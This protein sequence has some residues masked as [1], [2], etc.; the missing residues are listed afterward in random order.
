[1]KGLC[2]PARPHTTSEPSVGNSRSGAPVKAPMSDSFFETVTRVEPWNTLY[3]TPD[4]S[5]V[6]IFYL[7]RKTH[8]RGRCPHRPTECQR[9]PKPSKCDISFTKALF[10]DIVGNAF[11]H[12]AIKKPKVLAAQGILT[13]CA[14]LP[15]RVSTYTSGSRCLSLVLL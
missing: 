11:M 6:G 1:M 14:T 9:T 7:P 3:P 2:T 10:D 15:S 12:S 8:C 4:P 13:Y 5:G